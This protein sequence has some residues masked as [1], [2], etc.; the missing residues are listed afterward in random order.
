MPGLEPC[1]NKNIADLMQLHIYTTDILNMHLLMIGYL[2]ITGT[3]V[4]ESNLIFILT[5]NE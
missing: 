3:I 1:N 4:E 5:F 2:K